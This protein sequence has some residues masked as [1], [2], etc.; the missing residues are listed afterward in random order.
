[1]K[2]LIKNPVSYFGIIILAT[3]FLCGFG[4]STSKP[5]PDPLAGWQIDF[6]QPDAAIDKDYKNYIQ[7]LSLTRKDFVMSTTFH[8]DAKGGHAVGIQVG[9]NGTW[10]IHV[11]FY[12]QDDQRIRIIKYKNGGYRS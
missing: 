10:W 6:D 1:M 12:N 9:V 7:N 4:C 2:T 5:T 11:L 3:V 8:K